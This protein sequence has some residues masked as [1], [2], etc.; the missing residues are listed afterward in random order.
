MP[1]FEIK[2]NGSFEFKIPSHTDAWKEA[3]ALVV[4]AME[5]HSVFTKRDVFGVR[6]SL[7]EAFLNGIKHG[8]RQNGKKVV[9]ARGHIGP[10]RVWVSIEDQGDGFD[11]TKLPDPTDPQNLIKPSGRG[12]MLMCAFLSAVIFNKKGNKLWIERTPS[13]EPKDDDEDEHDAVLIIVSDETPT[14]AAQGLSS[15]TM[16]AAA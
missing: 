1:K 2:P 8:N 15:D 16:S 6:L 14:F 9:T 11:P 13:P 10:E 3:Q 5:E 7:E 4:S 12:V